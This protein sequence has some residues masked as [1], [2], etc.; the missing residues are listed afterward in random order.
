MSCFVEVGE[1]GLELLIKNRLLGPHEK[2]DR[3][4][5]QAAVSAALH[6]WSN[7]R[8]SRATVH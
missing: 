1:L 5:F 6:Q 4:A 2:S 8:G 3:K 7:G